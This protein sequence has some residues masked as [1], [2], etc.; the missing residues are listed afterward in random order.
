MV[1]MMKLSLNIQ[2]LMKQMKEKKIKEE[3]TIVLKLYEPLEGGI[4]VNDKIWI[5]KIQSIPLMDQITILDDVSSDCIPLTP[6]LSLELNDDIGYQIY[7]DLMIKWFNFFW[8]NTR[9]CLGSGFSL[10]TLEL[11]YTS[12]SGIPMG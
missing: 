1:L 10:D 7:D 4:D 9:I 12:G 5:S 8:C 2:L 11:E 3:K 6:N